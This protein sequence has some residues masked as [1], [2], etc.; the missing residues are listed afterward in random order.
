MLRIITHTG[1]RHLDDFLGLVF[2]IKYAQDNHQKFVIDYSDKIS[3]SYLINHKCIIIDVGGRYEPDKHNFDHHF[4][5]TLPCSAILVM[6][7]LLPELA[8]E[9]K[10][11][12]V[13]AYIDT[14]DKFGP[15]EASQKHNVPLSSELALKI[16]VFLE[17][18]NPILHNDIIISTLKESKDFVE[19][20]EKIYEAIP[21][22]Q[23]KISEY[24]QKS[25]EEKQKKL[26][27]LKNK[28]TVSQYK[29]ITYLVCNDAINGVTRELFEN[30][31][32]HVIICVNDRNSNQTSIIRNSF[33]DEEIIKRIDLSRYDENVVFRHNSGFIMVIDKPLSELDIENILSKIIS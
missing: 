3:P 19:W 2:A 26:E 15:K 14:L 6:N 25:Q 29:G 33:A 5:Q 11:N 17:Y 18:A 4:D 30:Y 24:Q 1:S 9:L 27:S 23:Q 7:K 12:P 21:S 32:A 16:R 10:D 22:L 20:I 8:K 13:L 31:N 28:I